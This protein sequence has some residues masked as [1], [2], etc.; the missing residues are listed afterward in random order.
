MNIGMMKVLDSLLGTAAVAVLPKPAELT[1]L[2]DIEAILI[3]RPGGIGDA[4]QLIP[5]VTA[6]R[7]T[8]P[9]ARIDILAERRNSPAFRLCPHVSS[10]FHYDNPKELL[11]V[12][13]CRYDVVID[14]EQWHRLSAV[15]ARITRS[16]VKI[17]FAVNRRARLFTH[18]VIYSHDDYEIE[19]FFRLFKPLGM[20]DNTVPGCYLNVPHDACEKSVELLADLKGRPFVT[21]FPGASISERRWG[22]EQFRRVADMLFQEDIRSVVVGGIEDKQQGENIVAGGAGINL[23]GR[24]S[25]SETAAVIDKSCLLISGDSGVL[26]IGVGLGKATVSLF[27]PGRA[28]KWAPRGARHIVINKGLSCSPCTTFGT[29]PTC[30]IDAQCLRDI[31]VT[32][33]VNAATLL[34]TSEGIV[35]R[36]C[37]K[38]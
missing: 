16:P 1:Q 14:S 34:L 2:K 19:S 29:T 21:I 23:A 4:V 10:V 18:R 13:R 31:S 15:V 5:A 11:H 28:D 25:L 33:V 27:G 20:M 32:D 22:S 30:L 3:I 35:Q 9:D 6:L 24:C 26:H 12:I 38:E 37:C 7:G 8:Y 36:R 17:G